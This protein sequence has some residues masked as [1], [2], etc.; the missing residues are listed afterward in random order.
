VRVAEG[1]RG[2][3]RNAMLC[4]ERPQIVLLVLQLLG[5]ARSDLPQLRVASVG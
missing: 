5:V 2:F 1:T 4:H 3:V